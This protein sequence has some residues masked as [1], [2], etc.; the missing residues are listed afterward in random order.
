MI[1]AGTAQLIDAVVGSTQVFSKAL[2]S[3]VED[4]VLQEAADA[5]VTPAQVTILK[6]INHSGSRT[7]SELAALLDVSNAAASKSVDRLV[8]RKL[9]FRREASSDR[10]LIDLSLTPL[11]RDV[12]ER[13]ESRRGEMLAR[14]FR[15][16]PAEELESAARVLERLSAALITNSPRSDEICLQCY[17]FGEKCAVRQTMPAECRSLRRRLRPRTAGTGGEA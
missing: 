13:Y 2:N 7:L 6:L 8:R 3:V 5:R 17:I 10:R 4:E 12:L 11:G 9:V 15:Q 16:F 1:E 14:T